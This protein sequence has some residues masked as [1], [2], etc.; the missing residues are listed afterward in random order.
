[1]KHLPSKRAS[2]LSRTLLS[3]AEVNP[4]RLLMTL[5]TPSIHH[6]FRVLANDPRRGL[7][8]LVTGAEGLAG[9]FT[10]RAPW[11]WLLPDLAPARLLCCCRCAQLRHARQIA[12]PR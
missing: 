10:R 2:R 5:F 8:F 9:E 3:T 6:G 4:D 7:P 1:M 12:V 11:D